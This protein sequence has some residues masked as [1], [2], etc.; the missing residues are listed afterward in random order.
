MRR[1]I[2]QNLA[3]NGQ[4]DTSHPLDEAAIAPGA[5][6]A[7]L[8]GA[9]ALTHTP[10]FLA[11]VESPELMQFFSDF[12]GAPAMTFSYKWIRAVGTGDFTGAHYDIVYM[13]RGTTN[14][15]TV[16]TPLGDVSFEKGPLAILEASH[17]LEKLKQT[18]GRMDVDRDN[19]AGWFSNDPVELVEQFGGRWLTTEFEMGDALIFGMFTMHASLNNVT[20]SYRL[21]CDTRYQRADEPADERWIG[22]NPIGH[23]AWGKGQT[24][25]MEEARKRWGI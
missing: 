11:V 3:T 9:K 17:R 10:E 1:V 4:I 6:G 13:G 20:S 12:L 19:V 16:W 15:Y 7:F 22:E 18:Y 23:Y 14:L 25:S 8:G 24:V 2:V 5:R 21:S